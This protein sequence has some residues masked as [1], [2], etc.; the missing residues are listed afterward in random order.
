[1]TQSFTVPGQL[2]GVNDL[3]K[4]AH[5]YARGDKETTTAIA[6]LAEQCLKPLTHPADFSFHW[7]CKDRRRSKDNVVGG[8]RYILNALVMAKIIPNDGWDWIRDFH[9][10]FSID[11]ANPRI[12]V[13]IT[14]ISEP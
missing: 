12:I 11:R 1:M 6:Y 2:P 4:S 3:L 9:D 8:R 14:Q 7:A 13:T 5:R 10:T